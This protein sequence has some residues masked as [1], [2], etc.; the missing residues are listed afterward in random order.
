MPRPRQFDRTRVIEA[1]IDVFWEHGYTQTSVC[2]LVRATGLKPGSLYGAFGS[3]KG[4][5][6]EVLDTYEQRFIKRLR[7][8]GRHESGALAGF[9]DL[10]DELI[11][12]AVLGRDRRGCLAVN[13][14]LEMAGH[15]A[16]IEAKIVRHNAGTRAAIAD[17]VRQAQAEDDIDARRDP[18]D[19]AAFI[20]NSVW[21]LRV[22]CKA[23]NN[24]H[25]LNAVA[26]GI[27]A[28]VGNRQQKARVR[29]TPA[30]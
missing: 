7:A 3:K 24:P 21:G 17:L 11:D 19:L 9:I 27:L 13:A 15:D 29:V 28:G 18:D 2:E 14:M 1:A 26:A 20:L 4:L 22:M 30:L 8:A 10:L 23:E 16:D 6:L 25:M 5:F 12:D